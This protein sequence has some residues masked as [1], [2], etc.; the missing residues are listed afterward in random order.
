MAL[1]R[2]R[3]RQL[4]WLA[5]IAALVL[6]YIL[7]GFVGVPYLVRTQLQS[8]VKERYGRALTVR[9][10]R[11]NPFTYRLE[12]RGVALPDSDGGPMLGFERLSIQLALSSLW[13]LAPS[14][15]EIVLEQPLVHAVVRPD[16]SLN[17]ADLA[18]GP[19]QA[20]PARPGRPEAPMRLFIDHLRVV[21]GG[22]AFEDRTLP[23]P[24]VEVLRPI[25][26]D[27]RD[28]STR[29]G[30]ANSY[31][32]TAASRSGA[33]LKWD[34]TFGVQ[35]LASHGSL[36]LSGLPLHTLWS[37]ER[38][39]LPIATPPG[40]VS[41]HARYDAALKGS[42]LGL[43]I[44]VPDI[45]V[46]GLKLR[47][48]N[49]TRD[50][51]DLPSIVVKDTRV[52]LGQHTVDIAAVVASG[53]SVDAWI[54][55]DGHVNLL[56][57]LPASP[58]AAAPSSSSTRTGPTGAAQSAARAAAAWRVS[59]PD[60][61]VQH[62]K[63][64]GEDREVTPAAK[65][66]VDPLD[67]KVAGYSTASGSPVDVSV[68]STVNGG[69]L[70]VTAKVTPDTGAVSG[71]LELGGL[72]LRSVQPYLS[73][74]TGMTLLSGLLGA[75][76]DIT[77]AAAG[78]MS[79]K[80][81]ARVS[82]LRTVDDEAGQDF[83]RWKDLHIAD[84]AYSSQPE[85]L[86]IGTITA[87]A[88]YARV[89][90]F[91][92]LTTNVSEIL[93]PKALL[94]G[95]ARK[96]TDTEGT[97]ADAGAPAAGEPAEGA[98][99]KEAT[100]APKEEEGRV[101]PPKPLVSQRKA[102]KTVARAAASGAPPLLRTSIGS[103]EVIDGSANYSDYWIQPNFAVGVQSLHGSVKGLSSN[104][105]SRAHV[106]LD[107]KVDRYAP[108][109]ITGV[110]NVLSATTYSDIQLSFQGVDM[111]SVTPYSGRFAGYKI[112]KGKLSVDVRYKIEN[113]QLDAQQHFVINQLQLGEKVESKDAVKLP[114]KLAI[115]LLKD[116]NGVIDIGLPMS[117]SLDDPKFKLGPLIWKA[118][119]NL[120]GKIVTAP[121]AALGHLFGGGETMNIVEFA[122][123]SAELDEGAKGKLG[124]VVKML[125]ERPG[126]QLNV[127]AAYQQDLDRQSLAAARLRQQ[128]L[129]AAQGKKHAAPADESVLA[130]P[131]D[132]F[133]LLLAAYRSQLK[134]VEVPATAQAAS[135]AKTK[136]AA[137]LDPAIHDLETA[138]VQHIQIPDSD[139]EQLGTLRAQA[140]E[141]V[142]V[143]GGVDAARIFVVKEHHEEKVPKDKSAPDKVP[144]EMSLK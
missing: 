19:A 141:D 109:H 65:L 71:K 144:V 117:G 96:V 127:P 131:E 62:L 123:G 40:T 75:H 140:I 139:L 102:G 49:G 76:L 16:G 1:D 116:R 51:V 13:R 45:T 128:L 83:V 112:D 28:F 87:R 84:I 77:R 138:L 101:E 121:F 26:F 31:E 24:F 57:L 115:A 124:S 111:T 122:P 20:P 106:Q 92:D 94:H 43:N 97:V 98:A 42:A 44:Q 47:P 114:V 33:H 119:V 8:F 85:S 132:H 129:E 95:R 12:I 64:A 50:Y 6:G 10:V 48:R 46:E 4:T 136:D 60:I 17:L 73:T 18:K 133:R 126:L 34:G 89:I 86:R 107:G 100:Q 99:D 3:R 120:L 103:I 29:T 79:V 81:D 59:V 25:N 38:S 143:A 142:I 110:I 15:R 72:D 104:P 137:T 66:S 74:Q 91:P 63:I 21:A 118:F 53:G 23:G 135:K 90:V 58:P 39:P 125:T 52:D 7:A 80:G 108:A 78:A 82:D 36:E 41:L 5:I 22:G 105:D 56:E 134:G 70:A 30:S 61:Q 67:V 14:Y 54:A 32:L 68:N 27:L 55:Q 130:N 37:Y 9:E 88:P 69:K 11:F 93:T 2:R 35:P 113:R